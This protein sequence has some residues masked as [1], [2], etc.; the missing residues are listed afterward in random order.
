MDPAKQLRRFLSFRRDEYNNVRLRRY[1]ILRD[2]IT[3]DGIREVAHDQIESRRRINEHI[4]NAFKG[5]EGLGL[6]QRD[7]YKLANSMGYGPDRLRAL[8]TMRMPRPSLDRALVK[9]A[10]E[11]GEQYINNVRMY[12]SEI[13][14]FPRYLTLDP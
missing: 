14:K 11:K 4:Y 13:S 8:R 7:I 5:F 1:N 2:D 6:G 12:S 9:K 3:E 10:R